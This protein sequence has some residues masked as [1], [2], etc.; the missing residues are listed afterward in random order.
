MNYKRNLIIKI[1]IAAVVVC[2]MLPGL[3]A[4]SSA[5][6]KSITPEPGNDNATT[7]TSSSI[8]GNIELGFCKKVIA[9]DNI[10]FSL[11]S[12]YGL[13]ILGLENISEPEILSR[14]RAPQPND[15][16]IIGSTA[17]IS[18]YI[19][20]IM[21]ID[22]ADYKNP[23]AA[24]SMSSP[25]QAFSIYC[26]DS[27]LFVTTQYTYYEKKFSNFIIY[28]ISDKVN[29]AQISYLDKLPWINDVFVDKSYVY[30]AFD[31]SADGTTGLIIVN[32]SDIN[33]PVLK[34]KLDTDGF[35]MNLSVK[36]DIVFL[37]D[38]K[39]GLKI[40][41]VKDKEKPVLAGSLA[42][43]NHTA[44][45]VLAGDFAYAADGYNGIK[46]ISINN[47]SAPKITGSID[48]LG[49]ARSLYVSGKYLYIAD[50]NFLTI[51]KKF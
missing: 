4:C 6:N 35:A 19:K 40:I 50:G 37:A 43:D 32:I 14:I 15:L 48:T 10:A 36:D 29:P 2:L 22:I 44:D 49:F 34:G 47:I 42:L 7:E 20:G 8:V 16:F 9:R 51:S 12:Y 33:N 5:G 26:T 17:Y 27:Y 46:K 21:I 18:D 41:D 24:G 30:L 39:K 38:D 23:V 11:D 31:D 28:D 25:N 45:I 3:A 13:N 1:I